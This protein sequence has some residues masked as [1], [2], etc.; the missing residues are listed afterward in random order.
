MA[1]ISWVDS[2]NTVEG[3]GMNNGND[4]TCD[5]SG[6]GLQQGDL[7]L[8]LG[9]LVTAN[10]TTN[11]LPSG[12][13]W[14]TTIA[15]SISNGTFTVG[16]KFMGSSPDTS[17]TITGDGVGTSGAS[18]TAI[19][20]RGVDPNTPFDV[21]PTEA[22]GTTGAPDPPSITPA[23]SG[24]AIVAI[25]YSRAAVDSTPGVCNSSFL[26]TTTGTY[27]GP[28][29]DSNDTQIVAQYMLNQSAS[30]PFNPPAYSTWTSATWAAVTAALR[31][32]V[33]APG[34]VT[35]LTATAI[36]GSRIDLS[37]SAPSP[38]SDPITG[39]FIERE[40][41]IG[42]GW[43]TLV[44]DTGN[45]NTTYQ[46]NSCEPETQYNYRVSAINAVGTGTASVAD[47]A[48]T[49]EEAAGVITALSMGPPYF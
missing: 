6:L 44:A 39:Y 43:G 42:G 19:A 20:F 45:T 4:P 40:S 41:P 46:D 23:T 28:G 9:G 7:V 17:I 26:P 18:L 15:N 34:Q 33:E 3:P 10:A 32:W 35:G 22:A 1:S 14:V 29:N 25:G 12:W 11:A 38:G 24:A 8:S 16:Y 49:P 37:W 30:V 21:T 31:P 2:A 47:D 13:N 27:R 48:T 5:L 36:S